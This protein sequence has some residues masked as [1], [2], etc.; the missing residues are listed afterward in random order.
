MVSPPLLQAKILV[1]CETRIHI[2]LLLGPQ[3]IRVNLYAKWQLELQ[4][5]GSLNK[6]ASVSSLVFKKPLL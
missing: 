4:D 5:T 6:R 1:Q 2:L 3:K